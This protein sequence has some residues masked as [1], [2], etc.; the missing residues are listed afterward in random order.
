MIWE[1]V[2]MYNTNSKALNNY[3]FAFWLNLQLF[4]H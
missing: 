4:L 3:Y 1:N 2:N